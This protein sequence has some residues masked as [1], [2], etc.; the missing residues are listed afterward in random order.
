MLK[1]ITV[2][3]YMV[4]N[5]TTFTPD[6]NVLEA[7]DLM[8]Q[9]NISGAPV[10]DHHGNLI[11]VLSEKDCMKVA[12]NASYH[13]ELGGRVEQFMS[14]GVK[15]VDADMNI[16]DLAKLFLEQPIKRYPVVDDNRLVGQISRRDVLLALQAL[17]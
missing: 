5:L 1:S 7:I 11:G 10:I 17:W 9:N 3:D 12:L 16:T 4:A 8:V 15:T 2:R 13:E 6:M 14:L